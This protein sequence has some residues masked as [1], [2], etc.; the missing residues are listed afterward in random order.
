M[1]NHGTAPSH[2]INAISGSPEMCARRDAANNRR[3]V[4]A[5]IQADIDAE[6]ARVAT[7]LPAAEAEVVKA[8]GGFIDG[9]Y[10]MV[11]DCALTI[12]GR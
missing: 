10:R 5:R 9:H 2:I 11:A 7:F 12:A 3:N 4:L 8:N 1:S 6:Y